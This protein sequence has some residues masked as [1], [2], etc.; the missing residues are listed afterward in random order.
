M[1]P[2]CVAG[3]HLLHI[4]IELNGIPIMAVIKELRMISRKG[5]ACAAAAIGRQ[6]SDV[7]F[8]IGLVHLL[9]RPHVHIVLTGAI[10]RA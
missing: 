9:V 10:P 8:D 5:G 3:I 6:E 4:G 7:C 2:D 1:Y